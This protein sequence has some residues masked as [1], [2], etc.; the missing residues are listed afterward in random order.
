MFELWI[1]SVMH[2]W[3]IWK[4]SAC[5]FRVWKWLSEYHF[6]FKKGEQWKSLRTYIFWVVLSCSRTLFLKNWRIPMV[7]ENGSFLGSSFDLFLIRK[8]FKNFLDLA[9]YSIF[10]WILKTESASHF[11]YQGP[12]KFLFPFD[13]NFNWWFL[14]FE[15]LVCS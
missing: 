15:N 3:C 12:L 9:W 10:F 2:V 13:E 6:I 1:F 7:P 8:Q 14:W 4:V 11:C 5:W